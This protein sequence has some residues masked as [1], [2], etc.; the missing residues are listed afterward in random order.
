M[1]RPDISTLID[2]N[3]VPYELDG[4]I[5]VNKVIKCGICAFRYD[6]EGWKV[7]AKNGEVYLP[8][9]CEYVPPMRTLDEIKKAMPYWADG[10][11]VDIG[12]KL[13]D[14]AYELGRSEQ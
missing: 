5:I 11:N 9:V 2:K 7:L 6:R 8:G 12:S 1:T 3:G 10:K 13:I 4:K 14:E